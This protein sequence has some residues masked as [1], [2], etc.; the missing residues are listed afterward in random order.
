MF[1]FDCDKWSLGSLIDVNIYINEC[2]QF[3]P[4]I[5][6][7]FSATIGF[8]D[9]ISISR[10]SSD[11]WNICHKEHSY[12]VSRDNFTCTNSEQVTNNILRFF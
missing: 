4:I 12:K 1:S 11:S 9:F 3:Y 6:N 10:D 7:I 2:T 8:M 5:I